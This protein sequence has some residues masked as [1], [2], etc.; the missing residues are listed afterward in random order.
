MTD[1]ISEWAEEYDIRVKWEYADLD[2]FLMG[3]CTRWPNLPNYNF[4]QINRK[5]QDSAGEREAQ[6]HEF[7]H[8]L[9]W[10]KDGYDGHHGGPFQK[11]YAI[12]YNQFERILWA[13]VQS[14]HVMLN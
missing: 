3:L 5:L 1:Y 9:A 13:I 4:I 14:I 2:G 6:W 12:E 11:Y 8:A 7:A 10:Q